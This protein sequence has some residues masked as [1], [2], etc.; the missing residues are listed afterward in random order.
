MVHAIPTIYKDI[1]FRSRLE[2]RW[3]K[4]FDEFGM[5]WDYEPHTFRI[6]LGDG[7]YEQYTPDFLIYG[8]VWHYVEVRGDQ[9]RMDREYGDW[10][11]KCEAIHDIEQIVL[12]GNL[13]ELN[14]TKWDRSPAFHA[15]K[16]GSQD[17]PQ[18]PIRYSLPTY[19]YFH[20]GN[21]FAEFGYSGYADAKFDLPKLDT[22]LSFSGGDYGPGAYARKVNRLLQRCAHVKF[23]N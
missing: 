10:I 4:F 8:G 1:Q 7:C 11:R 21:D 20:Q 18:G 15:W 3:A 6:D 12:L 2:A 9:N 16:F 22:G 14:M 5:V 19:A 23:Y 13:P 17:L